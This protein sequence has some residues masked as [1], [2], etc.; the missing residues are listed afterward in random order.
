M[1]WNLAKQNISRVQKH[2]KEQYYKNAKELIYKIGGRVMVY[3]PHSKIDK[4]RIVIYKG[5][6]ESWSV[7]PLGV[8][9]VVLVMMNWAGMQ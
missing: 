8:P 2:H 9:L 5:C 3:M 7:S 1:A 6:S 4:L